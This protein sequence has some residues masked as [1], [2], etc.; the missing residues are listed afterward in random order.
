MVEKNKIIWKEDLS[1]LDDNLV[2]KD[3]TKE[4]LV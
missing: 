3:V 4:L 2:D 1:V